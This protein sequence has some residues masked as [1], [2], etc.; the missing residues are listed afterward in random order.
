MNTNNFSHLISEQAKKYGN[1]TA[2]YSRFHQHAHWNMLSWIDFDKQVSSIAKAF[3]EIGINP[4]QCVGQFSQNKPE[5][6]IVDFALYANRGIV[7]PIYPTSSLTEVKHIIENA[8]I[9]LLFVGNSSQYE[10]A[11]EVMNESKFLKQIIIFDSDVKPLE[12]NKSMYFTDLMTIGDKSTKHTEVEARSTKLEESDLAC[13]LYTSGTSGVSKG[14]KISHGNLNET[15]R[16]HTLRLPKLSEKDS[17]IAYLPLTHIF[18]RTWSYFCLHKAVPIYINHLPQEIRQTL[19][20][21][22][23]NYICTVPRFWEKV[24]DVINAE[25]SSFSALKLA[26]FTWALAIGQKYHFEHLR[27]ARQPDLYLK[28]KYFIAEKLVFAKIKHKL[29]LEKTKMLPV[30]GARLSDELLEFFRSMGLPITYGYGL[31]ETTATVS[32]FE[33]IG[34]KIGSVGTIMPDINVKIGPQSEV[35]IKGKTVTPGYYKNPEADHEA[36][37]KDGWFRTGDAGYFQGNHL[38]LTDRIKDLYKTSNG[39]FVAP[40]KI[41]AVMTMDK[42][43]E[44][45]AVVGDDRNYITALIVPAM[46]E[47]VK[48]A[49]EQKIAFEDE[50]QLLQSE[51]IYDLM[52]ERIKLHQKD[53]VHYEHIRRFTL[54]PQTFSIETGELTNTLKMRRAVIMQKYKLLIDSMYN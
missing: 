44:Q 47:I 27:I 50:D 43:I 7:V 29:G 37:T 21:I 1:K 49:K 11:L 23:P 8:E 32:C 19:T 48:Y 53:M 31:T 4:Q 51:K 36:F 3:V 10:I 39:K 17:S 38:I 28:S 42:Y 2:L 6:L 22:K 40:Q 34:Y 52:D 24:Y 41:E 54:V 15:I 30:A 46:T 20:D 16:I 45:I 18:E 9:E 14:V 26:I 33:E 12:N 25:I 5:N 35:M 13:V